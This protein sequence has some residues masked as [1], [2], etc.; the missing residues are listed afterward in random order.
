[1]DE[2]S[3]TVR[4]VCHGCRQV[5]QYRSDEGVIRPMILPGNG[6]VWADKMPGGMVEVPCAVCGESEDPGWVPGF[7]PPV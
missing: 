4:T 6:T 3:A 5:T 2:V 7:L 1:M